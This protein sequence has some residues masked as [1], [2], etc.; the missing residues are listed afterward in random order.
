M[1]G[2]RCHMSCFTCQVSHVRCQ[3]SH[4]ILLIIFFGKSGGASR[5]R[6]CYQRGL[7]RLVL[8]LFQNFLEIYQF[9]KN[10]FSVIFNYFASNYQHWPNTFQY[11]PISFPLLTTQIS[12]LSKYFPGSFQRLLSW[13][14]PKTLNW[15]CLVENSNSEPGACL[16]S[17]LFGISKLSLGWARKKDIFTSW[18]WLGRGR[19]GIFIMS[20]AVAHNKVDI[21]RWN[22]LD[23]SGSFKTKLSNMG[24]NWSGWTKVPLSHVGKVYILLK[25]II[26]FIH[27]NV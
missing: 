16:G 12:V 11:F 13:L 3:V 6:V 14:Q 9:F 8:I 19:R 17:K 15:A 26:N 4:V 10:T 22:Q 21:S 24:L 20:L 23:P 25:V 2:V 18:A 1:S 27:D 5:R 7:P